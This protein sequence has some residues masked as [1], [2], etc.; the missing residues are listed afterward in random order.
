MSPYNTYYL[1]LPIIN[2]TKFVNQMFYHSDK[3]NSEQ[4]FTLVFSKC[5][6]IVHV[7]IQIL[8]RLKNE[9]KKLKKQI[10][11]FKLNLDTSKCRIALVIIPLSKCFM[12]I[13]NR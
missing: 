4:I 12:Q 3:I 13:Y 5:S 7:N 1:S 10:S 6:T 11:Y 9:N 8:E 2:V